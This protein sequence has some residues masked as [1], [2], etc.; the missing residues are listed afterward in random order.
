M[1]LR[2]AVL[3]FDFLMLDV[4]S[5]LVTFLVWNAIVCLNTITLLL[6]TPTSVYST[7]VLS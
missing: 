5:G 4:G 6:Y 7:P 3:Y 1:V 2:V